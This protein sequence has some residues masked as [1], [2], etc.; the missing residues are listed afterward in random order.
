MQWM[1][2]SL[3]HIHSQRTDTLPITAVCGKTLSENRWAQ[4]PSSRTWRFTDHVSRQNSEPA[5]TFT[6]YSP[7]EWS[8]HQRVSWSHGFSGLV[9]L[10]KSFQAHWVKPHG[11]WKSNGVLTNNQMLVAMSLQMLNIQ[12]KCRHE[13][14]T[15]FTLEVTIW[16]GTT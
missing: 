3:I 1:L 12:S 2:T 5:M 9:H 16:A 7:L 11:N 15:A 6:L 14:N 13:D 8:K 10:S 4:F